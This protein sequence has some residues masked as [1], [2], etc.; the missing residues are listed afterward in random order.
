MSRKWWTVLIVTVAVI[1]LF[2]AIKLMPYWATLVALGSFVF[3]CFSGYILKKKEIIEKIVEKPVEVIKE[4]KVPV[5]VIKEVIKE[6]PVYPVPDTADAEIIPEE[7][8]DAPVE[9]KPKPKKKN[10]NK[11]VAE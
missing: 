2:A 7:S 1:G 11:K 4:V 5:E 8:K 3:G 9:A 6:V 10:K